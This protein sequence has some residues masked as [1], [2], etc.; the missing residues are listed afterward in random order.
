MTIIR[1]SDNS[2]RIIISNNSNTDVL[3]WPNDEKLQKHW[4]LLI[5]SGEF[6]I[7]YFAMYGYAFD[8]N[9]CFFQFKNMKRK[10]KPKNIKKYGVQVE[11]FS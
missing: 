11:L 7:L 6:R 4:G 9:E 8:I 1:T 5:R 10:I 3:L 2:H